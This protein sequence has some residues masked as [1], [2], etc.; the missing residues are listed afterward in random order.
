MMATTVTS[1]QL[2][3]S[4]PPIISARNS[5]ALQNGT[6]KPAKPQGTSTPRV[7][8]EEIY[9]ALKASI[10]DNWQQYKATIAE[11]VM[12]KRN[13]RE[14]AWIIDPFL[15]GD[16]HREHLHNQLIMAIFANAQRDPPEHPGVA[17]WVAANDKPTAAAKPI[18][19]D[20]SEQRLKMEIMQI[21]ARERHRLKNLP[22]V[23]SG[24]VARTPVASTMLTSRRIQQMDSS[25]ALLQKQT[26]YRSSCLTRK[27]HQR[28]A[29]PEQVRGRPA[30]KS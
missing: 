29:T 13:Q 2:H 21:P 22:E 19:G 4:P 24:Y 17:S 3:S 8:L 1:S 9:T 15:R 28:V 16:S 30:F 14:V 11:F 20:A 26:V 7:D 18:T 23:S 6:P 5:I 27:P 25:N 12:G 10:G